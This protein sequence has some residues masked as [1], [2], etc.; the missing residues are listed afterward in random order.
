MKIGVLTS[1][2]ADYGIYLPLLKELKNDKFFELEIIAFGTHLSKY[3]GFTIT[4]I[5]SDGYDKIHKISSIENDDSEK[6]I[7]ISYA[8]TVIKFAEFWNKNIFDLIF[9]LGDR[10]EM[11]A[12]VQA[13]IPFGF[14]LAHFHGGETTLGAIDNIY[15]HQISLASQLHFVATE[16]FLDKV[17]SIIGDSKR[18]FNVGALSLDGINKIELPNWNDIIKSYDIPFKEF[19]LTTFHPETLFPK[20]NKVYIKTISNVLNELCGKF[21]IIITLPNADTMGNLYRDSFISLK[22]KN[23]LNIS[24]IENFGKYNYF[25]AMKASKFIIGNSSSAILESASFGKYAINVGHR[26]LGRLR[27]DNI[28]DVNFNKDD[29]INKV[30]KVLKKGP[31]T[32]INKYSKPNTSQNI[33]QILKDNEL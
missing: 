20:K 24:L 11:S 31:F 7:V 2:R 10:F 28:I 25:A 4:D 33:I 12:A 16:G 14:K 3:H 13:C 32:G 23:P 6:G 29:I 26:Q 22:D 21:H 9:C 5:V 17:R 15:R 27:N 1:S 19:I 30:N 8:K 18:I